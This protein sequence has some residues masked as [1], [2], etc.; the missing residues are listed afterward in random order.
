[1]AQEHVCRRG[2]RDTHAVWSAVGLR[3][4]GLSGSARVRVR[5]VS[6]VHVSVCPPNPAGLCG[7]C[8]LCGGSGGFVCGWSME[9]VAYGWPICMCCFGVHIA[10][11]CLSGVCVCVCE[12]HGLPV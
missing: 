8:L 2:S 11:L 6:P 9:P 1:M 4:T 7:A 5:P 12:V 3:M 10:N